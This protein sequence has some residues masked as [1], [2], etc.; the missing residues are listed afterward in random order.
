MVAEKE[1][2]SIE[3]AHMYTHILLFLAESF[4]NKNIQKNNQ[5]YTL[6]KLT[7]RTFNINLKH[8]L[9]ES[10]KERNRDDSKTL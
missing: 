1:Y 9:N 4:L 6:C 2:T 5:C 7:R 3:C 10:E 8:K